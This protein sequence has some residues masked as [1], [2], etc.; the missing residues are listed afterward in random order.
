MGSYYKIYLTD[1]ESQ[2][3]EYLQEKRE[4]AGANAA[5]NA[6]FKEALRSS[7]I[8][9]GVAEWRPSIAQGGAPSFK[10]VKP[11]AEPVERPARRRR[12]MAR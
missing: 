12:R 9:E 10:A 7:M 2:A 3:L 8:Q 11:V 1:D 6:L 5:A 4:K